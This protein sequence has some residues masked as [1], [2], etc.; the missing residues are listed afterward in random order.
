M[1]GRAG[2]RRKAGAGPG[3][4]DAPLAQPAHHPVAVALQPGVDQIQAAVEQDD[5]D[6]QADQR[7]PRR[8]E[9]LVRIDHR[10]QGARREPG[11]QQQDDRRDA[12]TRRDDLAGHGQPDNES[13]PGEDLRSAHRPGDRRCSSGPRAPG[14]H[15]G[16][17]HPGTAPASAVP[18][19]GP[20]GS[21]IGWLT[22]GPPGRDDGIDLAEEVDQGDRQECCTDN[23]L[24]LR[25]RPTGLA[26]DRTGDRPS[27]RLSP[28]G[29]AR[30]AH[31][32]QVPPRHTK[33][34]FPIS[35]A[36]DSR[37]RHR[38]ALGQRPSGQL[39]SPAASRT[40]W[41]TSLALTSSSL[42]TCFAAFSSA[43]SMACCTLLSPTMTRAACPSSMTSPNSLTS[44]RDM[45]RHRC[46]PTPPT[47]A[48]IAAPTMIEGGNKMPTT[49]PTAAPPHAPCRVAVSSL[50]TCT[51]PAWSLVTT[52]AS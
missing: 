22:A 27:G 32:H 9:D 20:G 4:R 10:G 44:A 38:I 24:D 50:F 7:R 39:T 13:Q 43:L 11:R 18:V 25:L 45:P 46:P 47:A 30:L 23:R 5:R 15:S 33:R 28:A 49:A 36:T 12:E 31:R 48:P 14:S 34:S 2:A 1:T 37:W 42:A 8:P 21:V 19:L 26:G 51:L 35:P 40:A 6:R 3:H 17:P 29:Q 16:F 41:S 52:A